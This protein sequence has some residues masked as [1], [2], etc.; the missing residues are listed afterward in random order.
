MFFRWIRSSQ[1][2]DEAWAEIW[3]LV[4][5]SNTAVKESTESRLSRSL[6]D[7]TAPTENER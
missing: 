6:S 5:G 4:E 7:P 3:R 2:L 1:Y